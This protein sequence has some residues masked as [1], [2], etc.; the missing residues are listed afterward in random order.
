MRPEFH[1]TTVAALVAVIDRGEPI[2]PVLA[3]ALEDVGCEDSDLLTDLR[4]SR[5]TARVC[6]AL[7][8]YAP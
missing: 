1:T 6:M 5:L 3:D 8:Y 7:R 4:A 2:L